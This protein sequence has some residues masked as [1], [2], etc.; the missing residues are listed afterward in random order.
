MS[1][2]G[3][4]WAKVYPDAMVLGNGR[5]LLY[6]GAMQ[7]HQRGTSVAGITSGDYYTADRWLWNDNNVG[8]TWT[9]SVEADG[10]GGSGL[11]KSLKMLV[12]TANASPAASDYMVLSQ[13][14]E[15]QDLQRTA[16]GSASAQQLT[17]SFW[18]KANVTGT[19][20]C[21]LADY[22]NGR[23]IS[24][25]YTISASGT[26]EYKSITFIGDT[27]GVFDNDNAA[28]VSVRWWLAAGSDNTSGTLQTSWGG[29]VPPNFAVGQTNLAA[30]VGNYWQITGVQLETGETATTFEHKKFGQELAECQRYYILFGSKSFVGQ[31]W[32]STQAVL[33]ANPPVTMRSANP[34]ITLVGSKIEVNEIG[35]AIRPG[36]IFDVTDGSDNSIGILVGGFSAF[37]DH[38]AVTW[39]GDPVAADAEL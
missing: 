6:N 28:S 2:V 36:S 10:P 4:V 30:S 16:K 31:A 7:V 27:T 38:A 13:V 14:L 8:V 33:F 26:W 12:T 17:L 11:G 5:N 9:Q 19:Y 21:Q 22:D 1:D 35:T 18:V 23:A 34:K 3:G 37:A 24:G 20:V 39:R 29:F 15:G 32:S 25:S